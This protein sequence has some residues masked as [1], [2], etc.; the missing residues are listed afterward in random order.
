MD[1]IIEDMNI[2]K[3]LDG[4]G[5]PTVEVDIIT[6]G[7]FGRA[8]APSGASTGV[9]EV[10]AFP[11]EGIGKIDEIEQNILKEIVGIYAEEIN[12]IDALLKGIDSR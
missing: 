1:S 4:R 9:R 3:I 12:T 6:E 2:R 10:T 7:G 8:A 5:N 11:E